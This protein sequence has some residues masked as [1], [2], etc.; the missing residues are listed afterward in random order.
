[1]WTNTILLFGA[2]Q[3]F[4]IAITQWTQNLKGIKTGA[5]VLM[6]LPK[7]SFMSDLQDEYHLYKF[8]MLKLKLLK[9]VQSNSKEPTRNSDDPK[10]RQEDSSSNIPEPSKSIANETKIIANENNDVANTKS[11]QSLK[12][13]QLIVF[14]IFTN[15]KKILSISL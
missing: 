14:L 1:M 12:T 6:V 13:F 5:S 10:K 7:E 11:K 8:L 4:Q 9:K 2:K 3:T 15:N